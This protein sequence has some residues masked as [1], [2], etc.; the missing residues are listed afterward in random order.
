M[1]FK[2]DELLTK[3]EATNIRQKSWAKQ[4]GIDLDNS[5]AENVNNDMQVVFSEENCENP[6]ELESAD[7]ISLRY[8]SGAVK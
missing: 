1:S 5:L 8:D 6:K 3:L 2:L 4:Q 7:I